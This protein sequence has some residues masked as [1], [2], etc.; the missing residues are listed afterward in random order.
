MNK[1][2]PAVV[3]GAL[4][5]LAVPVNAQD[6]NQLR[7]LGIPEGRVLLWERRPNMSEVPEQLRPSDYVS[8]P[9]GINALDVDIFAD[10][11]SPSHILEKIVT[12]EGF[13]NYLI[14]CDGQFS[15]GRQIDGTVCECDYSRILNLMNPCYW[16]TL[17]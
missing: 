4:L 13:I 14:L 3:L 11:F 9:E 5:I 12:S 8:V 2:I 1:F 17:E 16:K 7:S 15:P 6:L 10:R